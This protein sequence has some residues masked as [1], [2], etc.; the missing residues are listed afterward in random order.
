M[1]EMVFSYHL[2]LSAVEPGLAPA[3]QQ[4]AEVEQL[5]SNL[6]SCH[7]P[8]LS[9][10]VEKRTPS[11]S[12]WRAQLW[13]ASFPGLKKSF[14]PSLCDHFSLPNTCHQT[15]L[16]RTCSF[17]FVNF[18]FCLIR[19]DQDRRRLVMQLLENHLTIPFFPPLSVLYCESAASDA[20]TG[21]SLESWHQRRREST[22]IAGAG[23]PRH[24][25]AGTVCREQPPMPGAGSSS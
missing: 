2:H 12:F 16:I 23:L 17:S 14:Q 18:N 9:S 7:W 25:D 24:C 10:L 8:Q 21:E 13:V 5:F 3:I 1:M 4:G 20:E 6:P 15:I 11:L 22:G 19:V